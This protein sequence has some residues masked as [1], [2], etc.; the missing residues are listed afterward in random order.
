VPRPSPDPLAAPTAGLAPRW[1]PTPIEL[2]FGFAIG[3]GAAGAPLPVHAPRPPRAALEDVIR[4]HLRRPPCAVSFSGGRDSAAILALAADVARRDGL[5]LPIP[6]TNR[7][8]GVAEADETDWQERVVAHVGAPDWVRL[9]WDEELDAVGPFARQ[10]LTRFGAVIPFN[11]HFHLPLLE[12]VAGG[13]LLTGV[14]GDELFSG[15]PRGVA[16]GLVYRR[17]WPGRSQMRA[18]AVQSAPAPLR[19]LAARRRP[20][21]GF[22][23]LTQQGR[24]RLIAEYARST[25]GGSLRWDRALGTWW[26]GRAVQCGRASMSAVAALHDVTIAHPFGEPEAVAAFAAAAGP[27][28]LPGRTTALRELV[29]DLLPAEVLE[30]RGK[31]SFDP[32]FFGTPSRAFAAAWS[33]SAVDERYVDADGLRE[34]WSRPRPDPRSFLLLQHAWVTDAGGNA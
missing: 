14:G 20:P 28:G 3:D 10:V 23:W 24:R 25:A 8:P 17:R 26:G 27:T 30:R 13:S 31:A 5:P 29:G 4:A 6:I 22:G 15:H 34:E 1:R 18:L 2:A 33:G 9:D 19:R 11:A 32:A 12:R 7:F 16:A 21:A